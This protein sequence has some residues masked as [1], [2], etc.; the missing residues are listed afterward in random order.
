MA[1]R[2]YGSQINLVEDKWIILLDI[3][4]FE[5][6]SCLR[7]LGLF[8]KLHTL[9]Y[10]GQD[11]LID[12]VQFFLGGHLPVEDLLANNFDRIALLVFLHLVFGAIFLRI[13]HRVAFVAIGPELQEGRTFTSARPL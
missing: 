13:R 10:L 5:S 9:V 2:R 11:L 4:V 1:W 7:I 8:R 3:G 6:I 12:S